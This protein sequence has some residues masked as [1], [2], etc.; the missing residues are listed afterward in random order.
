MFDMR[1]REDLALTLIER[2]HAEEIYAMVDSNRTY[3]REWLG[4]VDGA[5]GTE[6]YRE[7]VIPAWLQ[8]FA[9]GDGCTAGI[10]HDGKF[11]GII[12]LHFINRQL[13]STSIGYYLREDAQGNGIMTDAVKALTD[14]CFDVLDLNKVTIQCATGNVKSRSIPERLGFSLEGISRD[15]EFINGHYNDIATYSL[16][17]KER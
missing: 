2:H 15:E 11:V 7:E 5:T 8:Q 10:R 17:R 1:I 9:E 16:L 13:R 3:L 6:L 14:Y 4:W 12:N